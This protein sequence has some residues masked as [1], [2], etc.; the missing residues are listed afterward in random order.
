MTRF[1][2]AATL[3]VVLVGSVLAAHRFARPD[4]RIVAQ[5][6]GTPTVERPASP[7]ALTSQAAFTGEGAWVL[8]A[9]PDCLREVERTRG[10]EAALAGK[11][12]AEA[13]RIGRSVAVRAGACTITVGAHDLI[14]QRGA[15]RLRVPP[16]AALYR[17]G[18]GFSLVVRTGRQ[19]EIRSYEP[20][21]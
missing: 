5:A 4:L 19:L 11:R 3:V 12:P 7:Q 21:P 6:S 16:E 13:D 14:V 20:A 9:L 8:S 17:A 1:Y 2:L 15:D 18:N 10:P